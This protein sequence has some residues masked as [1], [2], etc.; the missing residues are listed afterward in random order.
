MA[1]TT[2]S[3]TSAKTRCLIV[4]MKMKRSKF[5]RIEHPLKERRRLGNDRNVGAQGM[6]PK[7]R[8]VYTNQS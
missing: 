4:T 1:P 5:S 7:I 6:Q 2:A 8:N 3:A